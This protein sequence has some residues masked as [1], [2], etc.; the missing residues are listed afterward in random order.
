MSGSEFHKTTV[1][2]LLQDC[3]NKK[4]VTA[5]NL[6][7]KRVLKRLRTGGDGGGGDDDDEEEGI[8]D[9]SP[10]AVWLADPSD[11]THRDAAGECIWDVRN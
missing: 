1:Q 5:K 6:A 8:E 7:V 3:L 2:A 10:V 4:S 9:E 11:T